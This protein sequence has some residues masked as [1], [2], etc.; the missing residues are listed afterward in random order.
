M[1]S[2]CIILQ[3]SGMLGAGNPCLQH[4]SSSQGWTAGVVDTWHAATK[5]SEAA[6]S[7]TSARKKGQETPERSKDHHSICGGICSEKKM[8]ITQGLQRCSDAA[9][10]GS[11][12]EARGRKPLGA[13][14]LLTAVRQ[15]SHIYTH[16]HVT[17]Q[18]KCAQQLQHLV[19]LPEGRGRKPLGAA[20]G[21][22]STHKHTLPPPQHKYT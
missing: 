8:M 16:L 2:S 5:C 4:K 12:R 3:G 19:E 10:S 22:H 9:A 21:R 14:K 11:K 1:L 13:A 15:S 7:G 20:K 6:Q 17:L 18:I